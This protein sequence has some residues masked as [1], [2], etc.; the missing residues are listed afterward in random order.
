MAQTKKGVMLLFLFIFLGA[1]LGSILT[2][3]FNVFVPSGPLAHIFLSQ[4]T[5][6]SLHP[7]TIGLVLL[8]LTF[9]LQLHINLLNILGM[10]MGYYVYQSS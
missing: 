5:V 6:G 2:A 10:V 8:N 9:G 4:V 3:I 1:A 7:V